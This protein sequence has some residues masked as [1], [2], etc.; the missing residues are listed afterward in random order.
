MSDQEGDHILIGRT[1]DI[2][3]LAGARRDCYVV[4][5]QAFSLQEVNA[6]MASWQFQ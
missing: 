4:S 3:H 1:P 5:I 6:G 2:V